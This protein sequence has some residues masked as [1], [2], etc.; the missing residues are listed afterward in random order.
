[1]NHLIKERSYWQRQ[2]A[3]IPYSADLPTDISNKS[4][5]ASDCGND[6]VVIH[7]ARDSMNALVTIAQNS[8]VTLMTLLLAAFQV[9][10]ARH[11]NQDHIAVATPVTRRSYPETDYLIG[12]FDNLVFVRIDLSDNPIF[13]HLLKRVYH[14]VIEAMDYC[15]IPLPQIS[16][17]LWQVPPK[18]IARPITFSWTHL[19]DTF[20]NTKHLEGELYESG[21]ATN[22]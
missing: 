20:S 17:S 13:T 14:T 10:I 19:T 16:Q 12:C 6:P 15:A 8:N 5:P 1:M 18:L 21:F 22:S 4:E 3:D 9:L 7:I 2:L 11:T